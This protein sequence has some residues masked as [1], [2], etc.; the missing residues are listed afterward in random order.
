MPEKKQC[1]HCDKQYVNLNQHITKTHNKIIIELEYIPE[2][3]EYEIIVNGKYND[4]KL[5]EAYTI[6]NSKN[7][8]LKIDICIADDYIIKHNAEHNLTVDID[9][10]SF[11]IIKV[12][13]GWADKNKVK[14]IYKHNI[15]ITKKNIP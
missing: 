12:I 6:M 9:T 1:P 8:T 13:E 14:Q 10:K 3:D 2:Y 7:T 11:N 4:Y 5:S 15:T